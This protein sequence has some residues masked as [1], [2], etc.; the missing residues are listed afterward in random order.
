MFGRIFDGIRPYVAS[1]P[2][3]GAQQPTGQASQ[4]LPAETRP[5]LGAYNQQA[6][7]L[8]GRAP[9]AVPQL[10]NPFAGINFNLG[11]G[12]MPQLD[13]ASRYGTGIRGAWNRFGEMTQDP[14]WQQASRAAL[15]MYSGLSPQ[16]LQGLLSR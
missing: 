10:G 8:A 9:P 4:G 6:H 16:Q 14:R 13:A 7:S 1:N 2:F 3:R 11:G 15:G 12:A 5:V